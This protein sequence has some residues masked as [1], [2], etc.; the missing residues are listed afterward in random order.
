[1]TQS[2][3]SSVQLSERDVLLVLDNCEHLVGAP[4]HLLADTLVRGCSQLWAAP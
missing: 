2:R 4:A 1:M 3:R